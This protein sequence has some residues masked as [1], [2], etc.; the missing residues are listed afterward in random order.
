MNLSS[1]RLL[2]GIAA[3]ACATFLSAGA[4]AGSF[5]VSGDVGMSVGTADSGGTNTRFA[6]GFVF[7]NTGEDTDTTPSFGGS[8]G[9]EF[10][11][12]EVFP[13]EMPVPSWMGESFRFPRWK[14]RTELEGRARLDSDFLTDGASSATPY[15]S[16]VTSYTGMHNLWLDFPVHPPLAALFGRIPMLE[17]LSFYTGA[18]IGL[19]VHDIETSDTTSTGDDTTYHFAWQAG[20]GISYALT[21]WA[22]ISLGYRYASLGEPDIDL[23]DGPTDAGNFTLALTAHEVGTRIRFNFYSIPLGVDRYR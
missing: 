14:V 5:F 9:F 16:E 3:L 7:D 1:L 13:W 18:G 8:V 12:D 19:S 20:G 6:P 4:R 22:H 21:E 23:E 2:S 17:P 11:L 15:R 10:G